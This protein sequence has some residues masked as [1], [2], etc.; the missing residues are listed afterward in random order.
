MTLE[1][2][3]LIVI[4]MSAHVCFMFV[5]LYYVRKRFVRA[6]GRIFEIET[7]LNGFLNTYYYGDIEEALREIDEQE[8]KTKVDRDGNI[9]Y[10]KYRDK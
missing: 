4:F 2:T 3:T 8:N 1:T 9:L 10:I 7:K 6:Y 5:L